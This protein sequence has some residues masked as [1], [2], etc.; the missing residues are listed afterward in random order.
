P[1]KNPDDD[2]RDTTP[3]TVRITSQD[4]VNRQI[5]QNL[6]RLNDETEQLNHGLDKREMGLEQRENKLSD[7]RKA[8]DEATKEARDQSNAEQFRSAVKILE[9]VPPKQAKEWLLVLTKDGHVDQAVEY[10]NAMKPFAR[11]NVMKTF[12]GDDE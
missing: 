5:A 9:S 3:T 6:A 11:A 4:R 12:K 8:W 7:E 10:L 2:A 1:A